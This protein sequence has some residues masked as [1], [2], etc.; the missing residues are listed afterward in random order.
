MRAP[1]VFDIET[2]KTFREAPNHKDLGIS[3]VGAYDYKTETYHT[4]LE[5][6]L[7]DLF[8]LLE[9]ASVVVGYNSDGF[10]LPVLQAYYP[11]DVT[12]FK[13][14]D[15][16]SD[17]RR[18]LGRRIS[19]DEVVKATLGEGKSGNGLQAITYFRKG[20]W[21]ELK[22]YCLDD[23]RLTKELLDYGIKERKIYYNTP[24]GKQMITVLWEPQIRSTTSHDMSLT[25]PF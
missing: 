12:T 8:V 5:H 19:L 9:N 18:I 1:V 13:S 3:V 23:V 17:I 6:E 25:L 10:D 16:L 20:M 7:G 14:F 24:A 15:I 22:K 21:E 2:K 11:G 4:F